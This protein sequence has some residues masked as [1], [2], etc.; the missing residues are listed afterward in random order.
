MSSFDEHDDVR[1]DEGGGRR[2]RTDSL[3]FFVVDTTIEKIYSFEHWA[4]VEP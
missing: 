1:G 2:R 4:I 3:E